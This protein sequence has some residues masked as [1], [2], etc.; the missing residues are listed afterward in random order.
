MFNSIKY[1]VKENY[2]KLKM[3]NYSNSTPLIGIILIKYA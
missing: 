3:K 2:I 1:F